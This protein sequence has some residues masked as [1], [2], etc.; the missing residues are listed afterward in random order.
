LL[1]QL[2][3]IN[4]LLSNNTNLK[5][6]FLI[7]L[8][9]FF[10]TILLLGFAIPLNPPNGSWNRQI[11]PDLHGATLKDITF[12]DSLTGYAVTSVD[13]FNT[14]YILKTT[15]GGDSWFTSLSESSGFTKLGFVNNMTGYVGRY[16]A[17]NNNTLYRTTNGGGSWI[18]V[19][20]PTDVKPVDLSVLSAD[21]LWI[22]DDIPFA[23]GVFRT[24]DGG[25]SWERQ[26]N[27][28]N[29]SGIYMHNERIGFITGGTSASF[30]KTTDGGFNW[31]TIPGGPFLEIFFIDSLTGWKAN[32]DM[33]KTTDGGLNWVT[34][35]LP[36]GGIIL[37]SGIAGFSVLNRDTIFG[38]GGNI[39]NGGVHRRGILYRTTNGGENWLFQIP[40][41]SFGIGIFRDVQ[42]INN[43]IGWG[44]G[45]KANSSGVYWN[46]HT[47]NGGDTTFVLGLTQ[48]SSEIPEEFRLFQNYPNPF[49]PMTKLKFQM[50]KKGFVHLIVYDITGKQIAVLINQ[51]L[52][53]GTYET[54]FSS[55]SSGFNLSSG[56]YFYRLTVTDGKK[57]FAD[58]KKMILLK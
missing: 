11:M 20:T 12:T 49:N 14:G 56:V 18:V 51:E 37:N 17:A 33:K 1:L 21:L 25:I 40:D 9:L 16:I 58:T 6:L 47:T 31:S 45:S 48:I 36:T 27:G 26:F 50:S 5:K 24:T 15:D 3:Y 4:L 46:I 29:P 7:S 30:R 43:N 53:A 54:D 23:G 19:N 35:I 55:R 41:T 8:T 34:Q 52:S 57:I 2:K 32:G 22:V 13:S 28:N 42:F 44:F 39:S 10:T 38:A